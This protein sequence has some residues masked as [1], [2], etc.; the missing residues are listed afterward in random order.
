MADPA[1]KAGTHARVKLYCNGLTF[2]AESF[3]WNKSIGQGSIHP[4]G[5][6]TKDE[7]FDLSVDVSGTIGR[8]KRVGAEYGPVS[9][10]VMPSGAGTVEAAVRASVAF[11]GK[12]ID[13]YDV[14]TDAM[15][16]KIIGFRISGKGGSFSP[17]TRIEENLSYTAINYQ[18]QDELV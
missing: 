4:C 2:F 8:V 14:A 13:I 10:G 1:Q 3:S 12:D 11:Q 5:Q 6:L 18:D 15:I 16:G 9:E 17:A 7:I